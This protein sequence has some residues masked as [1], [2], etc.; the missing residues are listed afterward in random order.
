MSTFAI[1]G[2]ALGCV[3]LFIGAVVHFGKTSSVSAAS[4]RTRG[5]SPSGAG[6]DKLHLLVGMC[7][8]I[9]ENSLCPAE[10]ARILEVSG[11]ES[12]EAMLAMRDIL[13]A[14]LGSA[15]EGHFDGTPWHRT[16][17]RLKRCSTER[18]LEHAMRDLERAM[19]G[20]DPQLFAILACVVRAENA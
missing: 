3:L 14:S 13:R 5:R 12:A 19:D 16:Y 11:F 9:A 17:T 8:R 7:R 15:P 4:A 1:V 20:V 18:D 2:T 10:A 6:Q